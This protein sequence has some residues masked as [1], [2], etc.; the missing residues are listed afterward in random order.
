MPAAYIWIVFIF[1]IGLYSNLRIALGQMPKIR[2]EEV[3]KTAAAGRMIVG[4]GTICWFLWAAGV[5]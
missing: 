4:V 2:D 1:V 5:L 3:E